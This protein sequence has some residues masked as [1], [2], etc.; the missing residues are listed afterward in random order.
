MDKNSESK[1]ILQKMEIQ[2]QTIPGIDSI[3]FVSK[4]EALEEFKQDF[5]REIMET[6]PYNPLPPS[7]IV[8]PGD[9][10]NSAAQSKL[11]R[12]KLELLDGVEAISKVPGYLA[13][14][15]KWKMPVLLISLLCIL[16]IVSALALIVSNAIKL[17]LYAKRGL[18]ENMKY[19]GAGEAFITV[20]FMLEGLLLG[21][22]GS[23][24]GVLVT[25]TAFLFVKI[26]FPDSTFGGRAEIS[27]ALIIF[28]SILGSWAS[29]RTVR[30][31]IHEE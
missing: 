31:F 4:E 22:I 2:L 12:T 24:F 20:P 26:L 7:F 28:T 30:K 6:I 23:L 18:I 14:L 29:F 3:V 10:Y 8:Y 1:E 11:L 17:N 9:Y 19:C 5:D 21:F 15:D 13:W 27:A 16:F 25:F